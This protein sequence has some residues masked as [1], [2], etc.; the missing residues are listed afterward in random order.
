MVRVL[1]GATEARP[2]PHDG[3]TRFASIKGMKLRVTKNSIR[4]R[5]SMSDVRRFHEEGKVEEKLAIGS[6]VEQSFSYSLVSDSGA[7][8][9]AATIGNNTLIVSIP[10]AQ[11]LEWASTDRVGIEGSQ[12]ALDGSEVSILIEKDFACL[13]PRDGDDDKDSYPHPEAEKVC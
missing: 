2:A 12:S 7:A 4:L 8:S 1:A 3:A 11:A 10:V 6:G 9:V 13:T 5:L